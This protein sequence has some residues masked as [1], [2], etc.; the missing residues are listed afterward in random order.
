MLNTPDKFANELNTLIFD[1]VWKYNNPKVKKS[2]LVKGKEK[3]GLNMVDFTLFDKALKKICWVKRLCSKGDQA[4]NLASGVGGTL[5]FQCNYDIK[6][7]NL[8]PD[9]PIFHK[10]V[11]LYWQ[12]LN[13][14]VPTTKKDVRDQIV[15]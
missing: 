9:L 5:L 15:F 1:Y 12:E 2:A 14:V 6:Y 10:D 8:N 3:G 11:I 4:W 13:N 7:L